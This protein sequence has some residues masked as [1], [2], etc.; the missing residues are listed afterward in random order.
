MIF[1]MLEQFQDF[2]KLPFHIVKLKYGK[3]Y[4]HKYYEFFHIFEWGGHDIWK[5]KE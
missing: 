3:T 2:Y 1:C 4:F 5:E